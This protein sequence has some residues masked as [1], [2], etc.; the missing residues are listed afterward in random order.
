MDDLRI[1]VTADICPNYGLQ[2]EIL[3]GEGVRL[4]GPAKALIDEADLVIGNLE[5][6]LCDREA[7]IPK[8][9]PN[10][11]CKPALASALK[12]LGFH[13]LTL[14]NNHVN[15]QGTQGL[16]QTLQVLSDAGL[17]YCGAGLTHEAACRPAVFKVRERTVAVFNFGEGEFAQAQEEGPGAARLDAWWPERSIQ[18][19]RGDVDVILAVLHVGNE[20]QPIPSQVTADFC[21]RIAAAGADA[22]VAHHAHIPQAMEL[23]DGVPICFSLGNFLFG[24]PFT[25]ERFKAQPCWF[26]GS[27]ARLVVPVGDTVQMSL[28]PFK[29]TANRSLADLSPQGLDAFGEYM[30]RCEQILADPATHQR[31]WEQEARALFRGHRAAL[32]QYVADLNGQDPAKAHRAATILYNLVRCDAH[33]EALRR[34]FRLM[35]E[36]RLE[37]D[38][39]VQAE[40][41][42]LADLVRGCFAE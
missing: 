39:G 15:D 32:P 11:I 40:L 30:R 36:G 6:P 18:N 33:H 35:Y 37:D 10:F 13:C 31:F 42:A 12:D 19:V 9:G 27:L 29:Q 16:E 7:P 2:D 8:C 26:L 25:P 38:A 14:A 5:T 22:V 4:L 41:S 34:G 20:Y 1:L 21:R 17:A 28:Y 3:A 23:F 24:Y